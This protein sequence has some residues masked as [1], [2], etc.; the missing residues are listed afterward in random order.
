[1]TYIIPLLTYRHNPLTDNIHNH[2]TYTYIIPLMNYTVPLL[3]YIFPLPNYLHD[4]L[5][6]LHTQSPYRTIYTF[7]ILTYILN[8]LSDNL[9][10]HLT[11]LHN[12][13]TDLH[14]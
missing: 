7:P 14:T 4:L 2:L 8:P 1:M 6:F 5:T 9:H 11:D 13:I 3:T 12:P 10:N